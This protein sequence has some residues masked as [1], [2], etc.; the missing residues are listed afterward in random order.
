[1]HTLAFF[2]EAVKS[3]DVRNKRRSERLDRVAPA[4]TITIQNNKKQLRNLPLKVVH[5]PTMEGLLLKPSI[6]TFRASKPGH[7][8]IDFSLPEQMM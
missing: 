6:P 1:M 5:V 8:F 7:Y 3:Q 4:C 2:F